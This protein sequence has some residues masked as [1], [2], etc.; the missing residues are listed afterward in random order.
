MAKDPTIFD[1][2]RYNLEQKI[3]ERQQQIDILERANEELQAEIDATNKAM[4]RMPWNDRVDANN[5]IHDAETKIRAN[6]EDIKKYTDE[7]RA[8]EQEIGEHMKLK[9]GSNDR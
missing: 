6:N 8:F 3:K 5:D 2:A 7:I 4:D 9:D 1:Q